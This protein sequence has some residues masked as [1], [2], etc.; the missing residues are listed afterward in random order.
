MPGI[1]PHVA[2]EWMG[3]GNVIANKHY[4]QVTNDHFALAVQGGSEESVRIPVQSDAAKAGG[5]LTS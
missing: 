3:H 5:S 4:R 1:P 2:A